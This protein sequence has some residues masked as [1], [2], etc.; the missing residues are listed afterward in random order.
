MS[1]VAIKKAP[2]KGLL[3]TITGIVQLSPKT[4]KKIIIALSISL[5]CIGGYI[6][7]TPYLIIFKMKTA[8]TEENY[9]VLEKN[10]NFQA[11]RK[12]FKQQM[13]ATIM[14]DIAERSKTDT[15]AR[16][17]A[18][19]LLG[20]ADEF[21]EKFITPKELVIFIQG[22]SLL[23][24]AL[25]LTTKATANELNKRKMQMNL[26]NQAE[27]GYES[28]NTFS[29]RFTTNNGETI[30]FILERQGVIAWKL[31]NITLPSNFGL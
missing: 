4:M 8:F 30:K 14:K 2:A 15:F 17:Q 21:V 11:L 6:I 10:I 26:L 5:I 24:S 27:Y 16:I 22:K 7:A 1:V 18:G 23:N 29:L 28:I 25:N 12:A 3:K 9:Q 19:F 31:A 13:K 20:L